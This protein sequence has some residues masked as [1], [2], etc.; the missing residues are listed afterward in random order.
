MLFNSF[1]FLVFFP[2]VV[3]LY[4]LMGG[5]R[6]IAGRSLVNYRWVLLLV[7]SYFFYMAWKPVYILLIVIST[8]VDYFCGW[9][10]GQLT[11]RR[12]RKPYLWLSLLANLGIP[13]HIQILQFF[14]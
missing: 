2:T 13:L 8:L 11:E 7:A 6:K 3:F 4:F 10:M 12:R 14:Q 9:K 1:E 5:K